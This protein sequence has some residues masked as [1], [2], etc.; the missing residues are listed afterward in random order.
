MVLSK[1]KDTAEAFLVGSPPTARH[2]RRVVS[3]ITRIRIRAS[4]RASTRV[5]A[6]ALARTRASACAHARS[7]PGAC[8]QAFSARRA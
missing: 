5:T 4:A 3:Q 2:E 7:R 8:A 1:M 6:H